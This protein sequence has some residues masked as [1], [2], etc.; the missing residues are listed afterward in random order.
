MLG[1]SLVL[2]IKKI[3]TKT[4]VASKYNFSTHLGLFWSNFI[5]IVFFFNFS[6]LN[7]IKHGLKCF[8]NLFEIK[9]TEFFHSC[10][11]PLPYIAGNFR[12]CYKLYYNRS[13]SYEIHALPNSMFLVYRSMEISQLP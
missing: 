8:R 13:G 12:N 2:E 4:S 7:F 5:I 3:Q 9:R 6:L 11:F 1:K 10:V